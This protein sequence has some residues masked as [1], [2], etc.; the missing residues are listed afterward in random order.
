MDVVREHLGITAEGHKCYSYTGNQWRLKVT[1]AIDVTTVEKIL[2]AP[3]LGIQ[4]SFEQAVPLRP[5][6]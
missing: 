5:L 3:W 4:E 1:R 2:F 6:G